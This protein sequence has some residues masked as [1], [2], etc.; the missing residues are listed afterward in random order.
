MAEVVEALEGQIAPVEC[1]TSSP[2]GSVHC[3]LE[4]D[5]QHVCTSK[6]LWTRVRGA[7]VETLEQ[8]TLA[9]L[10][11]APDL[12]QITTPTA[13]PTSSSTT[14]TTNKKAVAA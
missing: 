3:S 8:T 5:A 14:T 11:P 7:I 6:V 1:I 4:S 10:I 12:I 13:T 9:D 2:D